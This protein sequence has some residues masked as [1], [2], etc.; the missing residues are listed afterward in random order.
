M[1]YTGSKGWGRCP[2]SQD[3]HHKSLHSLNN[4]SLSSH[5]SGGQKSKATLQLSHLTV[6]AYGATV[7][8]AWPQ[9]PLWVGISH[10]F[11]TL[12]V[13][14]ATC[15]CQVALVVPSSLQPY[16]LE[17]ARLLCPWD[18]SGKNTGVGCCALLQGIF[19]A[20][21]SNSHLLHWQAG[22]LPLAPPGKPHIMAPMLANVHPGG[23]R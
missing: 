6:P 12:S 9:G 14:S 10:F 2:V 22:S 15:M 21:G 7:G 18:S 3:G 4:R 20:Q 13:Y 8:S 16:G 1:V 11:P 5:S 19:P 17:P 23:G